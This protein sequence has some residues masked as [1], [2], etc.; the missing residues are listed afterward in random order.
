MTEGIKSLRRLQMGRETTAG[1]A[2]AATFAWRGEGT[3]QDDSPIMF[4]VEDIGL[5]G[6]TNRTYQ[7]NK[8]ASL[9]MESTPAT[10]EQLPHIFEAGVMTATP[11]ADG[12][13]SGYIRTYQFP[14][15]AT[16]TLKTYT[17]EGG[18][19]IQAEKME[20]SFVESIELDGAANEAW[21]VSANWQGRQISK[22]TFTA[23]ASAP[24]PAVEEILFN[25]TKVYIDAI[26]GTEG[27]TQVSNTVLSCNV[28]INTGWQRVFSADGNLYFSFIKGAGHEI[29]GSITYEHNTS[30][31]AEKDA[32][33]AQTARLLQIK[34][35]GSA[36]TT[37]G[38]AYGKKTL[39]MN[40][41]IKYESVEALGEQDGNDIVTL[42]FRALYDSNFGESQIIIVN[43]V[44]A[45]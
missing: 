20:Y 2:V 19:N 12:S 44:A 22:T 42:N 37:A 10:F 30:A 25:T 18:D 11:A 3:L 15:T 24:A 6:R 26:D 4:P 16:N 21:M 27:T 8:A 9:P 14:S 23:A 5:I 28:S 29:T 13:G 31:V 41:P 40:L 43:D 1:T 32:W 45:L 35:E 33:A 38:T 7:P 17:I 39:I 36:F 34:A